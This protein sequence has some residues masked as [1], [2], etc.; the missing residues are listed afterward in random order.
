MTVDFSQFLSY[1]AAL[2]SGSVMV[3]VKGEDLISL[4]LGLP[5]PACFPLKGIQLEVESPESDFTKTDT[6]ARSTETHPEEIVA[7]CQYM[8]SDGLNQFNAWIKQYLVD[9]FLPGYNNWDFLIQAGGTQSLDAIFRMLLN[10]GED[11]VLCETLTYP[12]FIE[13][14]APLRI[15]T[16]AVEMD[17]EGIVP[18]KLEQTLQNWDTNDSTKN[19]KKPKLIYLMPTGHN[20]TGITLSSERRQQVVELANKYNFLIVEDDPYYHL[21]LENT[22][23]VPSLLKFDTEGRVLRI[24]SFSKMLMP[25]LRVSIVTANDLFISKLRMHNE[26]SIHSAAS[27]SQMILQM[28]FSKWGKTGFSQ[29]LSHLQDLYRARRKVMLDAFDKYIPKDLVSY[30]RPNYGMFIWVN[31]DLN[32][33]KK[34]QGSTL[35]D[36]EWAVIVE[37]EIYNTAIK[38][39][40]VLAKGHWFMHDTKM[41]KAGFRATYSFV[42]E[43]KMVKSAELLGEALKIS[44]ETLCKN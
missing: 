20:P 44:Y 3:R 40:V 23:H 11:T 4:S 29:W 35:S 2:R 33:F 8:S 42:D 17:D 1:E 41:V 27:S 7:S 26:L 37:D 6:I 32:V 36:S 13:T 14:C 12:C 5:S 22:D 39:K 18:E 34:P 9:F 21:Q 10:P 43:S 38:C 19:L 31:V 30:N 25:G 16:V 15:K 24:D 28:I